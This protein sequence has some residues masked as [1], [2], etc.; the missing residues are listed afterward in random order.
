MQQEVFDKV[1]KSKFFNELSALRKKKIR[2]SH[3]YKKDVTG[4]SGHDKMLKIKL[5]I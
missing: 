5:L 4:I 2:A 3:T 1:K